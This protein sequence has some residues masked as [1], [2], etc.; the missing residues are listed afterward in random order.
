MTD[1]KT[2]DHLDAE[3]QTYIRSLRSENARF[4]TEKNDFQSK[5]NDSASLMA[6][7]NKKLGEFETLQSTYEKT[8][9][10]IEKEKDR[11][12]RLAAVAKFKLDPDEDMDRLKGSTLEELTADAEKLAARLGGVKP[13]IPLDP[14]AKEKPAAPKV[15]PIAQ[16]FKDAGL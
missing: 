4:R 16:A 5:Y 7:A 2:I 14:A 10:E 9:T 12:N 13:V 6:E 15:D 3:T 11:S 1:D 8:L